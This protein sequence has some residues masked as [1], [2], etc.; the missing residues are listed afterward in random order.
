MPPHNALVIGHR[1]HIHSY[2]DDGTT[3]GNTTNNPSS[4]S[5]QEEVDIHHPTTGTTNGNRSDPVDD[6]DA[7]SLL[8]LGR[9]A[10][11]WSM[12]SNGNSNNSSYDDDD[13]D[14][15][16]SDCTIVERFQELEDQLLHRQ[17]RLEHIAESLSIIHSNSATAATTASSVPLQSRY[18]HWYHALVDWIPKTILRSVWAREHQVARQKRQ[19]L[20]D[21]VQLVL[22]FI[23]EEEEEYDKYLEK[24][25][26]EAV[27]RIG[28]KLTELLAEQTPPPPDSIQ[29]HWQSILSCILFEIYVTIPSTFHLILHSLVYY[30][31]FELVDGC[32]QYIYRYFHTSYSEAPTDPTKSSFFQYWF[33]GGILLLGIWSMRISGYL[34]W[35]LNDIDYDCLKLDYRNRR[36]LG[37]VG[38]RLMGKLRKH[39]MARMVVFM[40]S[41]SLCYIVVLK[42]FETIEHIFFAQS[43]EILLANLPS[44]IWD[45]STSTTAASVPDFML[46]QYTCQE[47][48]DQREQRRSELVEADEIYTSQVLSTDSYYTYWL[49]RV[50]N[51]SIPMLSTPHA[52]FFHCL[53]TIV[54][55]IAVLRIY[56]FKFWE[57]Y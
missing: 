8:S 14:S 39:D 40:I 48:M 29:T 27:Q 11:E 9:H 41:Y 4:S 30:A 54:V 25:H 34:Y 10:D 15:I 47:I 57:Q 51:E 35:W 55:T 26:R 24:H 17:H 52:N 13:E 53:C 28:Q 45:T 37:Y 21:E 19:A 49:A 50:H 36:K 12:G 1:R 7:S 20:L 6:D 2:E 43:P 56:G 44:R 18:N 22:F 32:V 3:T 46:C 38:A 31:F 33:Y 16:S 23:E 42:I 5:D